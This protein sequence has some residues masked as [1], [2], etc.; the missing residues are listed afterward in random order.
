LA[1]S[2]ARALH[3]RALLCGFIAFCGY[4]K[5]QPTQPRLFLPLLVLAAPLTAAVRPTALQIALAMFLLDAARPSLLGKLGAPAY[6]PRSVLHVPREEQY[7]ADMSQWKVQ[8][9]YWAAVDR[10]AGL[11]H[12]RNRQQR[13]HTGIPAA[14][15]AA[16]EKPAR[17]GSFMSM[18]ATP[19][20]NTRRQ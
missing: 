19:R 8:P 14:C 7:F 18:C 20:R 15:A 2:P 12:Y 4:L 13:V 3:R 16:C 9:S 17:G 6:G 11:Q 5:W 1:R 10:V